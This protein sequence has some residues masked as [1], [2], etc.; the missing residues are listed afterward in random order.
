MFPSHDLNE[1][2]GGNENQPGKVDISPETLQHLT[3]FIVGGAGT[4]GLRSINV[5][6]KWA[7]S[8]DLEFRS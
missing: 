2:T 7:N 1:F 6:E 4:F 3:Q 8:E 5:I